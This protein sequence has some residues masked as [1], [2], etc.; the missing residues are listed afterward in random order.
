[1]FD[2]W[3]AIKQLEKYKA[4][5]ASGDSYN[6]SRHLRSIHPLSSLADLTVPLLQNIEKQLK[7]D[8]QIVRQVCYLI[9]CIFLYFVCF[10]RVFG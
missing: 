3:Q 2:V 6:E 1:M 4:D 7:S 9:D 10:Y 5:S 8:L